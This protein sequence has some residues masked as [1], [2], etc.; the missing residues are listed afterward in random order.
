VRGR[1]CSGDTEAH[2]GAGRNALSA[3]SPNMAPGSGMNSKLAVTCAQSAGL[4]ERTPLCL[5]PS[6]WGPY[7]GPSCPG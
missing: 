2:R 1:T 6:A 4:P 3:G 7:M 5:K